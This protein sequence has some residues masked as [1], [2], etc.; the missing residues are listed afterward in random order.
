MRMYG[1]SEVRP[2][3]SAR[4][5]V[6]RTLKSHGV[7]VDT[8]G[9]RV[10]NVAVIGVTLFITTGGV[11]DAA[12]TY[13]NCTQLNKA[14]PHGVGK[15]GARD[16]TSGTPVTNFKRSRPLYRANKKSDRD[17]DGIACEKA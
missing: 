2:S 6:C 5:N 16:K 4:A 8:N 13:S 3:R 11:A 7:H 10:K 1:H 14:H 17:G 12:K 15:P 9:M